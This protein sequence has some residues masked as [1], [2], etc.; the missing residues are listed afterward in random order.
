MV[1]GVV[2]MVGEG[3]GLPLVLF[4]ASWVGL[5]WAVE[6]GLSSS[7]VSSLCG[8]G[9]G[10]TESVGAALVGFVCASISNSSFVATAVGAIVG[11]AVGRGLFVMVHLSARR[12]VFRPSGYLGY[13]FTGITG[14]LGGLLGGDPI[15]IL[16]VTFR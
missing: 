6:M 7:F 8:L 3:G 1:R 5:F 11:G 13:G 2:V 10:C 15:T 4:V 12:S 14:G 16:S 9:G